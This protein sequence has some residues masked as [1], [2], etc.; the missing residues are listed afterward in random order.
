[1]PI[2]ILPEQLINQIAAGEV[3]E[4]PASVV[5]ELIE[6]SLDAGATSID[7]EVERGGISR[8]LVRDDGC[9]IGKDELPLA[10]ARHATSKIAALADLERVGTLGFRGEA[11]PSIG[12]V[13][14]FTLTSRA[15]GAAEAWSVR[16]DGRGGLSELAP[17][18]HQ[19]GT[20]ADVRELFFSVPARRKFLRTEATEFGHLETVVRRLALSH[21]D[22]RWRLSH[23][24]RETWRLPA[25]D[26]R[27]ACEARIAALCGDDFIA[28]T[29][30]IEHAAGG[31]GLRG[32]IGLPTAARART[33]RQYFYVNGRMVR[34]KLIAHA[35]RQGYDDV[36]FH[37][38]HP[39]FVLYLDIDPAAV[40]VNAHP[41]KHEVR[42]RDGR[43]VHDQ[44]FHAL[45][46][47][48]AETRPHSAP[49][50]ES[51]T[52]FHYTPPT[53]T[54][55]SMPEHRGSGS[56]ADSM[57]AYA[58]LS[59]SAEAAGPVPGPAQVETPEDEPPMGFAIGQYRGI[60]ILAQRSD[61][62]VLV[63]MH[64]A[65]ERV[66]YE[67]MKRALADGG[68]KAV[69]LLVPV[70]VQ[71][72]AAEAERLCEDAAEL[73]RLGLEIDRLGPSSI[74]VRS[75]PLEL[76][77]TDVAALVREI[78]ADLM[79]EGGSKGLSG[80]IERVLATLACHR[81]VRAGRQLTLAE[82]NA[83]LRAMEQTDRA[84]QCNHGRPTWTRL[85]LTELDRLF[86][87]GQ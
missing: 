35:V 71:L 64:A 57:A 55:L 8:M 24:G 66:T 81:A 32:W 17:A 37:G 67:Q 2:R 30:Y 40:D 68:I 27:A 5:K 78:A 4:R 11:L 19:D 14:E 41:A 70:T 83:L 53:Q 44:I 59:A 87:R 7:V 31:V 72:T 84:D 85:S 80:S 74:A 63:D 49:V 58:A 79:A 62:L 86:L 76:R 56:V 10:L 45:H 38:R 16:S 29:R 69:P 21:Y 61:G 22:V 6:N 3:I 75:L 9:G 25:C 50:A 36:L 43:R 23:N 47:A 77:N 18:A 1:M 48:L 12:S 54:R 13:S 60:Y 51:A 28:N 46:E 26:D 82:M 20:S 73:A 33:D 15:R 42:F 34:D 52:A 39:S 65:H